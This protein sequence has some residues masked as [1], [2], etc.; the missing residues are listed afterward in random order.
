MHQ[1]QTQLYFEFI[2]PA[3]GTSAAGGGT[4]DFGTSPVF[5]QLSGKP[6]CLP[7]WNHV[8]C[9]KLKNND[10][11]ELIRRAAWPLSARA[12]SRRWNAAGMPLSGRC[13]I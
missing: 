3:D 1:P 11:R 4:G 5:G 6:F 13:L 2:V 8:G 7:V 10:G 9:R 12:G